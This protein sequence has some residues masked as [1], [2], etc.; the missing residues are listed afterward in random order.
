[1]GVLVKFIKQESREYSLINLNILELVNKLFY[2]V[3]IVKINN[4]SILG[5]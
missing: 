4:F 2:G 3:V 1:M 5:L